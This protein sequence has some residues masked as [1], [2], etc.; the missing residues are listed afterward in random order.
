[1]NNSHC[2][3]AMSEAR[4]A[5]LLNRAPMIRTIL[6]PEAEMSPPASTAQDKSEH[7]G[8]LLDEMIAFWRVVQHGGFSQAARAYGVEPSSMSRSVARLEKAL[9]SK[10]L[11]RSYRSLALTELGEQVL[12]ECAQI[13]GA[14]ITVHGLAARYGAR[15]AGVLCVSAPVVLG[16]LWLASRIAGFAETCP[17]VE[18]RLELSDQP[19][20]IVAEGIDVALRITASPPQDLAARKLFETPY[21]LVASP[22]YLRENGAP[23]RPEALMQHRCIHLGYGAFDAKWPLRRGAEHVEIAIAPR[24]AIGNSLALATAAE[25]GAG[26][27]LIPWFS[28]EAA[29]EGGRLVMVLPDWVP[30]GSYARSAYLLYAPGSRMPPKVRAFIDY[31]VETL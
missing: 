29:I 2:G 4:R 6:P 7:Q 28:A 23:D 21:V 31:L 15:P 19:F 18:V 14:A 25:Q 9:H 5:A 12:R 17:E 24:H 20:D 30:D 8:L 22:G 10:L 16:Q 11:V 26:I 1:M 3:E 13:R 27:A